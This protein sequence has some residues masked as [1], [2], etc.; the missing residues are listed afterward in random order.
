V[1]IT[2]DEEVG[3]VF[4]RVT[5]SL[6]RCRSDSS[7]RTYSGIFARKLQFD[8]SL[9]LQTTHV[10][11]EVLVFRGSL[12]ISNGSDVRF[13]LHCEH[14]FTFCLVRPLLFRGSELS[15]YFH[16]TLESCIWWQL[17]QIVSTLIVVG[18]LDIILIGRGMWS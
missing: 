5:L 1:T 14:E 3:T 9:P 4:Y 17:F 13:W 16:F 2:L 15:S 8:M 12:C 11:Y 18:A 7:G 10:V 6:K